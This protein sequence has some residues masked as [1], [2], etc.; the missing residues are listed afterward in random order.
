MC[1][2]RVS[3]AAGTHGRFCCQR[4][5][6]NTSQWKCFTKNTNTV[7]CLPQRC[8][9]AVSGTNAHPWTRHQRGT[10]A[11]CSHAAFNM[12][13]ADMFPV[14]S[15]FGKVEIMTFATCR[16]HLAGGLNPAKKANWQDVRMCSQ[17]KKDPLCLNTITISVHVSSRG[18]EDYRL[19]F[20]RTKSFLSDTH[21]DADTHTSIVRNHFSHPFHHFLTRS[22]HSHPILFKSKVCYWVF[23]ELE[24]FLLSFFAHL[25]PGSICILTQLNCHL[26]QNFN[27]HSLQPAHRSK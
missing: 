24:T 3:D 22:N 20:L 23:A 19:V 9:Y 12:P 15:L 4:S 6:P 25:P 11:A 2:S 26:I 1:S 13:L 27:Q 5:P 21:T 7:V 16:W 14:Y 17:A 8:V 10:M 18:A